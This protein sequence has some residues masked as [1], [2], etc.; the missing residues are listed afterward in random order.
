MSKVKKNN[1]EDFNKV[2]EGALEGDDEYVEKLFDM[3]KP[4]I[5]SVSN[6]FYFGDMDRDDLLQE[7]RLMILESLANFNRDKGVHFLGY[8]KSKLKYMY[9]NLNKEKNYEVSL[10]TRVELGEGSV[11]LMDI[12]EDESV[13][14]EVDFLNKVDVEN[15]RN[16]LGFL[17][18]REYQVV[19]MYY[20]ENMSMKD[21]SKKLNLAYRTVVNTKVNAVEKMRKILRVK[22][23]N[24]QILHRCSG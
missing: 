16:S 6:K 15:L 3:L 9:M 8:I 5:L 22:I 2:L 11:E 21:I 23:T 19:N 10:N 17:T 12:L 20:L 7:G 24:T 18:S 13:D 14:I 1:I 4:L